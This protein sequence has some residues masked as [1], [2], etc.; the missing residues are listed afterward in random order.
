MSTPL[1]HHVFNFN[2]GLLI[3]SKTIT[4]LCSYI[5]Q[6]YTTFVFSID[7][8]NTMTGNT[9]TGVR[10]SAATNNTY[11][12]PP[13]TGKQFDTPKKTIPTRL[14]RHGH[15]LGDKIFRK[16]ND[17]F[18]TIYDA[19]ATYPPQ[20]VLREYIARPANFTPVELRGGVQEEKREDIFEPFFLRASVERRDMIL[21]KLQHENRQSFENAARIECKLKDEGK[22]LRDGK[23]AVHPHPH[24]RSPPVPQ[25]ITEKQ[26]LPVVLCLIMATLLWSVKFLYLARIF[27]RLMVWEVVKIMV[28]L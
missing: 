28:G 3:V 23:V 26:F 17:L 6:H 27:V 4:F 7:I 2:F 13:Y 21:A 20:H 5:Y 1:T 16:Q 9:S 8:S 12:F 18:G 25:P 24:P 19:R 14:L 15:P 10:G 22:C 11:Y